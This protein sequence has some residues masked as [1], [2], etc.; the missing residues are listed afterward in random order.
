[1][2]TKVPIRLNDLAVL[3]TKYKK[4]PK[5]GHKRTC[6]SANAKGRK[7]NFEIIT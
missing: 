6:G 1:M 2:S 5:K 3:D 7:N 4:K